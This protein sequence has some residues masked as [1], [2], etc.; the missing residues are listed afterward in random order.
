MEKSDFLLFVN[1][2]YLEHLRKR[3]EFL[4]HN[5][6]EKTMLSERAFNIQI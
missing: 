4:P 5:L 1:T 3:R 2:V 6:V